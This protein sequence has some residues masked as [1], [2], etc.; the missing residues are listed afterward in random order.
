M[1]GMEKSVSLEIKRQAVH[2]AVGIAAAFLVAKGVVDWKFFLPV[3]LAGTA[4]SFVSVKKRLPVVSWFLEHFERRESF[5]GKGALFLVAG[6]LLA[7]LLFERS[8]A[9]AS[10]MIVTFGDSISHVSGKLFG[11]I[12]HPLNKYKLVE[13]SILGSAAAAIGAAFFVQWQEAVPA[14]AIAMIV[15]SFE[16]KFRGMAVDDN[17]LIPLVAGLVISVIRVI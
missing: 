3:L 7:V 13:G 17:L 8:I 5:P 15:E 9:L 2:I 1:V 11:K 6:M 12:R 10:I 4:L 14:A 16:L